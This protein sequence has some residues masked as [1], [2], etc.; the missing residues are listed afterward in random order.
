MRNTMRWLVLAA[1]LWAGTALAQSVGDKEWL[2]L[3]KAIQRGDADAPRLAVGSYGA[4]A[5][6]LLLTALQARQDP[7]REAAASELRDLARRDAESADLRQAM[8][9]L[10]ESLRDPDGEVVTTVASALAILG[11]SDAALAEARRAV[12]RSGESR[13]HVRFNAARGLIGLDPDPALLPELL[14][15]LF[16]NV[17]GNNRGNWD[18]EH[19]IVENHDIAM[20]ALTRLAARNDRRLIPPL[21]AELDTAH[22]VLPSIMRVLPYF[23]PDPE[24]WAEVLLDLT[25]SPGDNIREVAW[26]LLGKAD[27]PEQIAVW[28]PVALKALDDAGARAHALRAISQLRGVRA[29]GLERIAT[30]LLDTSADAGVREVAA[31]VL[32]DACSDNLGRGDAATKTAARRITQSAYRDLLSREPMGEL[33]EEV[34]GKLPY[35]ELGDLGVA[36]LALAAAERNPDPKAQ[37]VL[38]QTVAWAGERARPAFARTQAFTNSSDA[39]VKEAALAALDRLDAAWRARDARAA[40]TGASAA[41]SAS[42]AAATTAPSS[43]GGGVPVKPR[44]AAQALLKQR[45]LALGFPGLYEAVRRGD[46][47]AVAAQID[48]GVAINTPA[49][50]APA[51]QFKITPLQAVVDYCHITELVSQDKLLAMARALLARGADPAVRGSRERGALETAIDHQCPQPLIDVLVA[52]H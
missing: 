41:A 1:G 51:A 7:V 33:F 45:K 31:E 35:L 29:D 20:E 32:Y 4:K 42:S 3:E 22:P 16:D 49:Q 19:G 12:L 28:W 46:A 43:N 10:R 44:A 39:A 24:N 8:P 34:D 40:A 50:L 18:V 11:E 37:V 25:R 9:V 36:E 13:P 14:A 17:P 15:F 2:K 30:L 38:L 27:A 5:L 23:D 48:A 47:E 26:E 52:G 6:P 21:L